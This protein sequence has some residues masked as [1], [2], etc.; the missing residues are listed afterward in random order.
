MHVSADRARLD[1]AHRLLSQDG[2]PA[3]VDRL[4]ELATRLLGV[5]SA[6]A[7]LLTDTDVSPSPLDEWL[8]A[9]TASGTE[10]LVIPE[11]RADERVR[12]LPSV[13]CG[14]VGSYLGTPLVGRT[15]VVIGALGVYDPKP[16]E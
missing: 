14:A 12:N 2:G 16:R 15:G 6:Q 8:C 1:E 13:A 3:L 10:S 9:I 5:P 11:A 4:V 7:V